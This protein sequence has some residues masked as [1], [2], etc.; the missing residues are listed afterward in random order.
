ML[1]GT[2]DRACYTHVKKGLNVVL[3]NDSLE[4]F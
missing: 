3:V 4:E 2:N 1:V